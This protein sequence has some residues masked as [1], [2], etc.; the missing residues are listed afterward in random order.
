MS[1][2]GTQWGPLRGIQGAHKDLRGSK[3]NS[4]DKL[5][6]TGTNMLIPQHLIIMG[7]G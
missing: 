5:V 7:G 6:S 1:Q 2:W 4:R 3:E